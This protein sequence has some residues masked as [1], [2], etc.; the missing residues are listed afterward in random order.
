MYS[1]GSARLFLYKS[2]GITSRRP[3]QRLSK[4]ELPYSAGLATQWKNQPGK[5]IDQKFPNDRETLSCGSSERLPPGPR[6][7]G[8]SE[9]APPLAPRQQMEWACGR[10]GAASEGA[11]LSWNLWSGFQWDSGPVTFIRSNMVTPCVKL[12]S[13]LQS[14]WRGE[15]KHAL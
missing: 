7:H 9:H 3:S 12:I 8:E 2:C 4:V 10:L 6:P 5:P 11:G 13:Y 15:E 1:I 14:A